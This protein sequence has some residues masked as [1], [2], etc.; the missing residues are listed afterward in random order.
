MMQQDDLLVHKALKGDIEAF[1][2]LISAYEHRIYNIAYRMMGNPEDAMDVVQEALLKIYRSLKKFKNQSSFSTWIYRIVMN[3][4][5][6]EL[7]KKKRGFLLFMND[8]EGYGEDIVDSSGDSLPEESYERKERL[9]SLQKAIQELI[10]DYKSVII[11]RDIQGFS[12]EEIAEILHCPLGTVKSR[13][14]RARTELR[15]KLSEFGNI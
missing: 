15:K 12:Y 6:D 3:T 2:E 4:C 1:E 7:R 9:K 5:L 13:I 11:L 8:A 10:P 14:N